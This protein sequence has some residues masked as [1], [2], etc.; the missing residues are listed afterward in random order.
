MRDEIVRLCEDYSIVSEYASF[1]VLE[2]DAEYQRWKIERKNVARMGRDRAALDARREAL[3]LRREQA[4]RSTRSRSRSSR[5]KSLVNNAVGADAAGECREPTGGFRARRHAV[6]RGA[7]PTF[8]A[9]LSTSAAVMAAVVD[10]GGAIDPVSGVALLTF[11]GF[12]AWN[13]T[14]TSA[15]RRRRTLLTLQSDRRSRVLAPYCESVG[16]AWLPPSRT[17]RTVLSGTHPPSKDP[18]P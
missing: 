8:V 1:I 6:R 5:V 7:R 2:N 17:Q 18:S 12:G 16:R 9:E 15:D 10:G 3:R 13:A 11:A 4:T 14:P